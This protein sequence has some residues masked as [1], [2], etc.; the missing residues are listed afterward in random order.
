MKKG[1]EILCK[2]CC[3][4]F[5]PDEVHFRLMEPLAD[6]SIEPEQN[7]QEDSLF[8]TIGRRKSGE[9]NGSEKSNNGLV[10]D[11]RLYNYYK[12][13][14]SYDETNAKQ[15]AMQ[16]P[17]IE[18]DSM[19]DDIEFN[20]QEMNEYGYVN[21]IRYKNQDLDTRLC[22]NC[23]MHLLE[24][25]GKYDMLMFSVI[26]DTNVGKSVYLRVL[27]AM[28]EKGSFNATMFFIGTK[29]E[30]EYYTR[31]SRE[32]IQKRKALEATIGRV[33]ALTFQ[34]TYDNVALNN[35]ETVLITFCDI[36][37]EKC[38][39]YEDLQIYGKHLKASSGLMFLIDP[40]RF[41]R[42]RNTIDNAADIEQM[43]QMEV[44]SA[45]N[46][47][48]V[49]STYKTNI[50]IPTA[51][52]IT[53]C[54][55][56]KGLGYFQESDERKKL[57]NDPDWN[58]RHPKYLN[59]DEINKIHN[60]VED[61]LNSMDE[62]D[63]TRKVKDLFAS[64]CFF[65]NSSLGRSMS[66]DDNYDDLVKSASIN[67]YRIT[68]ALYW[69]MERNSLIP[70]KLTRVYKNSKSGEEREVSVYYFA[71]EA[72]AYVNSKMEQQKLN[73]SIKDSIFGGKWALVRE[74]H[75]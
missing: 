17:Y 54:D 66:I 58:N 69:M 65:I 11:E 1:K 3:S 20:I 48:L 68:E 44:V 33:P 16:L 25:A 28:I 22:P 13:Y 29:E 46:R 8:G 53:K 24:G 57:L 41:K 49:A 70:R 38:R 71:D 21:R 2:Y 5:M 7:E 26:G 36:A 47:F 51:I 72:L 37:G 15:D 30:K 19:N 45:I 35:R 31:T 50:D 12:A 59:S 10:L 61:F 55:T 52:M 4:R 75:H 34:L 6:T 73:H 32:L 62:Q 14:M 67:P 9:R 18:F 40:T 43:Y 39:D 74:S 60:G 23:H 27:E 64:Y 42:I 63:F 56:L